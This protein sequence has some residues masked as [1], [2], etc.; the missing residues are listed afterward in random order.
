MSHNHPKLST[1]I[2]AHRKISIGLFNIKKIKIKALEVF[3]ITGDYIYDFTS[4]LFICSTLFK[5]NYFY[6]DD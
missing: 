3:K 5:I 2:Q 4:F 1:P 6:M